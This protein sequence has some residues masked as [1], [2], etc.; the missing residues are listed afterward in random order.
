M[1][2]PFVVGNWKLY[3]DTPK[4]AAELCLS[5][6]RRARSFS[7]VEVAVAA[8][9]ALIPAVV[10]ALKGATIKVAAQS[11]SRDAEGPHTGEVSAAILAAVGTSMVIV[12]HSERRALGENNE[13]VHAQVVHTR[14]AGLGVVLCV[15][16]LNRDPADGAHFQFV[17][18]Q[19]TSALEGTAPS[20]AGSLA[21]AYEPVWAIGKS[22]AEAARPGDVHEMVIF[23]R[24]LLTERFGRQAASRV[25][26][27][28][29]GSVEG[30]NAAA[31]L[32]EGGINGFLVGRAS[33]DAESFITILKLCK[34]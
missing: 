16:E 28:Y 15:G 25:P 31:L 30:D 18:A 33:A 24:K 14:A 2:K 10:A 34:P 32:A 5:L 23:I 17:G 29:G 26:I 21:V 9:Y 11:V 8:P 1:K 7:G 3:I 4:R 20:L 13:A 19:L 27:L 12:G 22:A 6:R